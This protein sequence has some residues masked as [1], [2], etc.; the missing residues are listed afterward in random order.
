MLSGPGILAV[1]PALPV[2]NLQE[3]IALAKKE[4]GKLTFAS[5]GNGGSQHM[6][7]ELLKQRA[8]IDIVHV[9]YKGAAGALT[10]LIA[11]HVSMAFM[12]SVSAVPHIKAGSVRALAVA[13]AKRMPAL[14]ELP[15]FA[16]AGLPNF[17]SDSW[18]GLFAPAG[19]PAAIVNRLQA[20]VTRALASPGVRG[21][22][23]SQGGI[24]VGNSPAEFRSFIKQE[25][26][27]WS[28]QFKTVNVTL[29]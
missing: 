29:E 19:T 20:E 8:G 4:P 16:E 25:V 14:P 13:S 7:G 3:L 23:E 22:L 6:A 5:T 24:L 26:D 17:E 11:G 21:K 27:H 15:T 18:S 28:K 1:S 9:P 2:K 12:T 10:D